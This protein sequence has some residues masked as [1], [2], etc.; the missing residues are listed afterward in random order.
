[1][2]GL[3]RARQAY[4][5]LYDELSYWAPAEGRTEV[6][7]LLRRASEFVAIEVKAT[8]RPGAADLTGLRAVGKYAHLRASEVIIEQILKPRS[9]D[10]EYSPHII[11]SI[12][13]IRVFISLVVV[14]CRRSKEVNDL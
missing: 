8:A 1:M 11:G 6:D 9:L 12:N 13:A 2:A 14:A 7:F 3:L 10:A 5:G 4:T